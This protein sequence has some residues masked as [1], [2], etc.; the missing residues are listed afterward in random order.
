MF[1]KEDPIMEP[2]VTYALVDG[3]PETIINPSAVVE[4]ARSEDNPKA[5]RFLA[6]YNE[7]EALIAASNPSLSEQEIRGRAVL[8]AFHLLGARITTLV[9]E[10]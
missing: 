7:A 1:Q 5:R 10:K 4:L 3:R 2:R 9:E 8:A 6:F